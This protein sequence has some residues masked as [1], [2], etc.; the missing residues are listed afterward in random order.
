MNKA[1]RIENSKP[2]WTEDNDLEDYVDI[3]GDNLYKLRYYHLG[4]L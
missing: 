1:K 2:L 4:L 3:Y